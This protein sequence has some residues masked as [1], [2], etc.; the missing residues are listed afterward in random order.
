VIRRSEE[1]SV[2]APVVDL[3]EE[4]SNESFELPD[5]CRIVA[6]FRYGIELIEKKYAGLSAGVVEDVPKVDAS[7]PKEAAHDS[8]QIED[9]EGQPQAARNKTRGEGF[10]YPRR[11]YEENCR[12]GL[13]SGIQ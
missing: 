1:K 13:E 6:S 4:N 9:E 8:R 12:S 10:A 5:L 11:S 7:T 3:L 2:R